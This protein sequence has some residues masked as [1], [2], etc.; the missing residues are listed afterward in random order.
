MSPRINIGHRLCVV[1]VVV[2]WVIVDLPSTHRSPSRSKC[3]RGNSYCC[4]G[5]CCLVLVV[6]NALSL[7]PIFAIVPTTDHCVSPKSERASLF[8]VFELLFMFCV[9]SETVALPPWHARAHESDRDG[10]DGSRP[11]DDGAH[12]RHSTGN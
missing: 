10:H 5:D 9:R 4:L 7:Q 8:E 12:W 2:V 11:S 6:Q 3:D 1:T